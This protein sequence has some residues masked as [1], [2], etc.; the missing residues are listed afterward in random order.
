MQYGTISAIQNR[1]GWDNLEYVVTAY[2][3]RIGLYLDE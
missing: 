1:N 3:N 2:D